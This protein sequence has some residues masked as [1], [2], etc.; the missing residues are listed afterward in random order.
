MTPPTP[1]AAIDWFLKCEYYWDPFLVWALWWS[2]WLFSADLGRIWGRSVCVWGG[3]GEGYMLTSP[4]WGLWYHIPFCT[5][6][7]VW[8]MLVVFSN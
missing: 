1:T 4:P 6:D 5:L 8:V 2:N 3:G 7:W